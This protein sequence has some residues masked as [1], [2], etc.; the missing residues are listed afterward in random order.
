MSSEEP[1]PSIDEITAE[2]TPAI[3]ERVFVCDQVWGE[4]VYAEYEGVRAGK[5][6]FLEGRNSYGEEIYIERPTHFWRVTLPAAP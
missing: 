3:G 4:W 1:I 2:N 6:L 5:Y